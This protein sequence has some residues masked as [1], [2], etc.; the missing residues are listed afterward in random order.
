[1]GEEDL[2]DPQPVPESNGTELRFAPQPGTTPRANGRSP[3][4]TDPPHIEAAEAAPCASLHPDHGGNEAQILVI[5]IGRNWISRRRSITDREAPAHTSLPQGLLS[6]A[7][8]PRY[9]LSKTGARPS[10]GVDDLLGSQRDE[11]ALW[12]ID[13]RSPEQKHLKLDSLLVP[14]PGGGRVPDWLWT[15][16][17]VKA[18]LVRDGR[19]LLLRR[20]T[21]LN[22]WPGHW[23]LPGGGVYRS[24]RDLETALR[25]S[26]LEE[27][28]L[29]IKVERPVHVTLGPVRQKGERPFPSLLT[30]F[31][32]RALTRLDPRLDKAEHTAFVW[33]TELDARA[34]RIIPSLRAA[35]EGAFEK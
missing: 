20:R 29:R 12:K 6:S 16:A 23:D 32:C 27:T 24:D 18:I 17:G 22:L 8:P 34:L 30:C 14:M 35:I 19:L 10:R 7:A 3:R 26:V 28:G 1:M 25:R 31:R 9:V 15:R 33:A 13:T 5:S 4:P 11:L 21:D 2:L